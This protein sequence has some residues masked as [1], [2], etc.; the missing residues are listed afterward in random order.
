MNQADVSEVFQ[1][2][3]DSDF[4]TGSGVFPFPVFWLEVKIDF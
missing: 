4:W 1:L 2:S 3:D